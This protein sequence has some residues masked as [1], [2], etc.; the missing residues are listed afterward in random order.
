MIRKR[1]KYNSDFMSEKM[2]EQLEL[3]EE[4]LTALYASTATEV[5]A[6][7]MA[8]SES[9]KEADMEMLA[10]LEAG[11]ITQAEYSLWVQ[12]NIL[13]SDLYS[14]TVD[15]LTT[16][17]VN[18]DIAAMAMVN[19]EL[20]FV[21]A[22]SYNFTQSL[23][24]AAADKAGLSVGT[25]QVY[26][27]KS[28]EILLKKDPNLFPLPKVDIPEDKKWNQTKINQQIASSML[29]G[30]T[31]PQVAENLQ[32]VTDMDKNSAIRNARTAMTGAENMGRNESAAYLKEK[33]IPVREQW[34]A[35]HDNRTRDTHVML[36]G[37]YQDE[38][39]YFGAD[40]LATPLRFAGDPLGDPEEVYNCRCRTSIVLEGIDHSKDD[41]L[42][43]Q[44]M[45]ENDPK[46]YEELKERGII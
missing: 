39:G 25:F 35:T 7:F 4:R 37:T 36:D 10:K 41:E 16:M 26:N 46:S 18:A 15:S 6:K 45:K 2:D 29:K 21:I 13:Q 14:A 22:Q 38:N 19:G 23:G 24:F 30:D 32:K 12:K 5:N 42:Y 8:F 33:G 31:I 1:L 28:V 3:L 17:M 27:A 9:F 20:P 34:S 43:E 11:E 44:F 40:F